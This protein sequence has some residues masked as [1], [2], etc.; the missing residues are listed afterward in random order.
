MSK[1]G[2]RIRVLRIKRGLS[3]TQ[4]A[5]AMGL[6]RSAIGNYE[7]GIR[8]P[9][10][11]TIEAFADFFDTSIADLMGREEGSI[12]HTLNDIG[13]QLTAPSR[14]KEWITLSEGLEEIEK[15]NKKTFDA[16]YAFLTTAYPETFK[17]RTDD[18]DP[19]S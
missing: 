3:Q 13:Q 18:D 14:S 15:K 6:K 1:V 7:L 19:K 10:L 12:Y 16:I 4:L 2:D 17:E 5:D 8:E 9:D 11:D